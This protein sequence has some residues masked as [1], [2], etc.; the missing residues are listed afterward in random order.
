L[1]YSPRCSWLVG[2]LR[3]LIRFQTNM[4]TNYPTI[5]LLSHLAVKGM[6]LTA[7]TVLTQLQTRGVIST[8]F[9]S[10]K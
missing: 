6:F 3:H 9:F 10:V 5:I 8:I 4:P 1:S 2:C 7:P